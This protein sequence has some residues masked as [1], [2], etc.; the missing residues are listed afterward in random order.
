M[1]AVSGGLGKGSAG[2]ALGGAA[3]SVK[4]FVGATRQHDDITCL[5]LRTF[6]VGG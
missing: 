6:A 1:L 2:E 4:S 3:A 5:L